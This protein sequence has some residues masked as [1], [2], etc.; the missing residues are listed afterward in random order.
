MKGRIHVEL[1]STTIYNLKATK[2]DIELFIQYDIG[3]VRKDIHTY[4]HTHIQMYKLDEDW[5]EMYTHSC[6]LWVV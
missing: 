4:V 6:C 2:P 5:K 1:I 3:C